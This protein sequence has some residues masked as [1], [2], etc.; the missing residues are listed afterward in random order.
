MTVIIPDEQESQTELLFQS[1][2]ASVSALRK[3]IQDLTKQVDAG[4]D[5]DFASGTKAL[6]SA[7]GLVCMCQKT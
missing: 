4:E 2:H 7:E 3:T 1:L 5:T 6:A